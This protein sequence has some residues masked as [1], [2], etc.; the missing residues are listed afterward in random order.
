MKSSTLLCGG[1]YPK[2]TMAFVTTGDKIPPT[3]P[4]KN[5]IT[6]KV[7][8]I[9]KITRRPGTNLFLRSLVNVIFSEPTRDFLYLFLK[10]LMSKKA[11]DILLYLDLSVDYLAYFCSMAYILFAI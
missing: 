1:E 10:I 5:L 4:N 2:M 9:G 3:N 8:K 11:S 6:K 7:I